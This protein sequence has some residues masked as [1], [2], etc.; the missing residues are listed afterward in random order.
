MIFHTIYERENTTDAGGRSR[1]EHL[2]DIPPKRTQMPEIKNKIP[3][4]VRPDIRPDSG[5]ERK[6]EDMKERVVKLATMGLSAAMV[7]GTAV[8][9]LAANNEIT[10]TRTFTISAKTDDTHSYDVYQILKGDLAGTKADGS[11]SGKKLVRTTKE[12]QTRHL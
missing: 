7:M 12:T 9:V 11:D 1:R 3:P 6:R 2:P 8:P 10:D 4:A 5:K